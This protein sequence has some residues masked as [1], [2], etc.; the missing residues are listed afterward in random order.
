MEKLLAAR[1]DPGSLGEKFCHP[2]C[3]CDKCEQLHNR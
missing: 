3:F 2:L 1:G